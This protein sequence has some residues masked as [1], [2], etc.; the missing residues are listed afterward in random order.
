MFSMMRGRRYRVDAIYGSAATYVL[1]FDA[2]CLR[3]PHDTMPRL[4][5]DDILPLR[6]DVA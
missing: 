5:A 1:R 3:L 2:A 6:V 4:C